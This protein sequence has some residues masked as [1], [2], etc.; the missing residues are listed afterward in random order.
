M[1]K[2][3]TVETLSGYVNLNNIPGDKRA[4]QRAWSEF[5]RNGKF[6]D[7]SGGFFFRAVS[8]LKNRPEVVYE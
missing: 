3:Y 6:L 5:K 4:R 7:A 2:A 8:N 1:T